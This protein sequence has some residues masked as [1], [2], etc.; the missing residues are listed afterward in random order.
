[1]HHQLQQL[2]CLGLELQRLDPVAH[3]DSLHRGGATAERIRGVT[4]TAP[5]GR[6]LGE[7]YWSNQLTG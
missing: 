5:T 6:A 2:T 4:A 7:P 3:T 1:M